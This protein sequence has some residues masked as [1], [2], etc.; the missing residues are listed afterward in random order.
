[1]PEPKEEKAPKP[2]KTSVVVVSCNR[3][4]LL[5]RCLKTLS[6]S[7]ARD[8]MEVLVVDNGS[9]D[10]SAQV[11]DDFRFTRFIRIPRNFGLTK[12]MNLGIRAAQGEYVF[13]LHD[14]TE[15]APET[16][17]EL[18]AKLDADTDV[19]AVAPMLVTGHGNPAPQVGKFP[20]DGEWRP[21]FDAGQAGM[22]EHPQPIAVDHVRG[23]ALM[24]RRFFLTAMREID[25]RYGQYGSDA[26]LCYQ[27]RRAGKKILILPN[28]R[29][30]HQGG[31]DSTL[32][33]ADIRT[34]IAAWLGKYSG[35]VAA[36]KYRAAAALGSL[37]RLQLGQ[38]SYIL[39]GR[40]IDGTQ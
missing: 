31:A 1:M 16:V 39:S 9:T 8:E 22:P 15:V 13:F 21:A 14:D 4:E 5:R 6:Q 38:F 32:K 19:T 36:L 26:D 2:L 3:V 40:K 12:A 10:G 20:P 24:V 7:E 37:V 29:V 35:F 28:L 34:G 11:E 30:V 18:A 25:E 27:I 23:A 17:R 33:R